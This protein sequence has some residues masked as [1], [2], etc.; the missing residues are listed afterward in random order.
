M[1]HLPILP[2]PVTAKQRLAIIPE[3]QAEGGINGYG[4]KDCG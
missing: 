4:G 3:D 2:P 1:P